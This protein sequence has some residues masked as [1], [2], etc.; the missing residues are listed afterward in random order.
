MAEKL[1]PFY[2]LLKAEIAIKI[3]SELKETFDS[4]N[5]ALG[6]ACELALKQPIPRKQFV[7]K[8]D[9]SLRSADYALMIEDIP[10]QKIRSKRKT[11]APVAFGSKLFSP[12]QLKMSIYSKEF[13]AIRMAFLEIALILWEVTKPTIVLTDNKSVTRFF[14]TKA[15]PPSL[16][17]ACDYVLQ[18]NFK[19]AHNAGSVNT[20]V[21]FF[22]RLELK[23]TERIRL[24][25]REVVQTTPIEVT[26]SSSDVADEE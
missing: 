10:D 19:I 17:N 9:A 15:I 24:N 14:Q 23:V 12:A 7:L 26:T 18:F 22:S 16:R 11:Y 6:D 5:K 21:D 20:A 4:V 1:N 13:L 3:T 25:I 8:T 2:I